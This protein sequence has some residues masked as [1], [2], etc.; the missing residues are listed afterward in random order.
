MVILSS[1]LKLHEEP[2]TPNTQRS[3]LNLQKYTF[4]PFQISN[5]TRSPNNK[6]KM[7]HL[8]EVTT[9]C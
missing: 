7:Q 6:E 2:T 1:A 8:R 4:T 3:P 5:T 9:S